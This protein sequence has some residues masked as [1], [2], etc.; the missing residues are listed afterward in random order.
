MNILNFVWERRL[1]LITACFSVVVLLLAIL[2]PEER[3]G[4][5]VR[6]VYFHASIAENA[7]IFFLLAA[8]LAV[9]YFA[10]KNRKSFLRAK[11]F[12][13]VGFYLWVLQ[14][15]LGGLNMKIIWGEFFWTEPKARMGLVLLLLSVIIYVA[16]EVVS[17]ESTLSGLYVLMGVSAIAGLVFTSNV[18]HPKNAIFGS[19]VLIYKVS[20]VLL[21]ALF[22]IV[23]VLWSMS[24]F[25]SITSK[26]E[27]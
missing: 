13:L 24:I 10:G 18:F 5:K 3:L 17:A 11:S 25:K 14:T 4:S 23:S 15:I 19:N 20:F 1:I 9:V 2:P 7:I 16:S 6:L 22:F 26:W 27:K 12:F 8:A 21:V